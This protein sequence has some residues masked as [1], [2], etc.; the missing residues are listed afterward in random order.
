E[1]YLQHIFSLCS[2]FNGQRPVLLISKPELVKRIFITD[3]HL[4]RNRPESPARHHIFGL[5]LVAA[6]GEMWKRQRSILNPMFSI[7]KLKKMEE[8][9]ATGVKAM[10]ESLEAISIS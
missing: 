4:V 1:S 3:F 8:M 6:N 9:M 5:N 10:I 7:T 2:T